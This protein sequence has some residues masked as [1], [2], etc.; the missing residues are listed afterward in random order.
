MAGNDGCGRPARA[1]QRVAGNR[2]AKPAKRDEEID[3]ASSLMGIC[4]KVFQ[5]RLKNQIIL[6]KAVETGFYS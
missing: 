3:A 1:W 4:R 5:A 2:F 6:K